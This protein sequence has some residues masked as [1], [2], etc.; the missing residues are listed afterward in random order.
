MRCFYGFVSSSV[1]ILEESFKN[2]KYLLLCKFANIKSYRCR[3]E[4]TDVV[5][6]ISA[7]CNE[8][9]FGFFP[10]AKEINF[11]NSNELK[12]QICILGLISKWLYIYFFFPYETAFTATLPFFLFSTVHNSSSIKP[13][14]SL[15]IPSPVTVLVLTHG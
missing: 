4:I 8:I 9:T 3:T 13:S 6:E 14:Q 15:S 1:S 11:I 2:Q 10:R 7:I 12:W 5:I